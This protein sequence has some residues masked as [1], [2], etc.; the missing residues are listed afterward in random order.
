MIENIRE[1]VMIYVE[2]TKIT[3]VKRKKTQRSNVY[4]EKNFVDLLIAK[5]RSTDIEI[6]KM[7]MI[8]VNLFRNSYHLY[9]ALMTLTRRVERMMKIVASE[10][11]NVQTIR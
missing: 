6:E 1:R 11:V 2:L 8:D 10:I 3:I 9:I 4:R 7:K 5:K